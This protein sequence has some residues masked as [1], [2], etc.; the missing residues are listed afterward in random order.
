MYDKARK[1]FASQ[2]DEIR[3]AGT[4]KEER[5]TASPR[6]AEILVNGR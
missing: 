1:V 2:L 3:A 6:G 5:L 4:G